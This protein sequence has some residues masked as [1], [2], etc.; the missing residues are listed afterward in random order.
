MCSKTIIPN[1]LNVWTDS[2]ENK[3][4]LLIGSNSLN[5]VT[6]SG[7]NIDNNYRE[8]TI[9]VSMG[10]RLVMYASI[11]SILLS[12]LLCKAPLAIQNVYIEQPVVTHFFSVAAIIKKTQH[13]MF[14]ESLIPITEPG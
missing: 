10:P 14:P 3:A 9:I 1:A 8:A 2:G 12:W 5:T 4:I 6:R 11:D 7:K 13:V